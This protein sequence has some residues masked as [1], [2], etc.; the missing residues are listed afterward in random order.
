MTTSRKK[1]GV[2]FWATVLVVVVLVLYPLS[3]GP[4]EWLVNSLPE[5]NFS[6]AAN[7]YD[8]AYCPL[9]FTAEHCK[10]IN[11]ALIWYTNLF[12]PE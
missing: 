5:G 9:W 4:A 6:A 10:P 11:S 3:V 2:A 8:V 7:A 1:P 12:A